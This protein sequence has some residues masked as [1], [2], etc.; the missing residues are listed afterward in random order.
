MNQ[1]LSDLLMVERTWAGLL[2]IKYFVA[3]LCGR[4]L[5]AVF[6]YREE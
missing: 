6:M 2:T 5:T 4:P 3:K 1:K